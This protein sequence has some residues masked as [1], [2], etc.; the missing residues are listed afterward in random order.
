MRLLPIVVGKTRYRN[1]LPFNP[2]I[3]QNSAAPSD[4][5]VCS[6]NDWIRSFFGSCPRK[7]LVGVQSRSRT[8]GERC[9][10][11]FQDDHNALYFRP[12]FARGLCLERDYEPSIRCRSRSNTPTGSNHCLRHW[13]V[14]RGRPTIRG[15]NGALQL[16]TY[17]TNRTRNSTGPQP[18]RSSF[19]W[20]CSRDPKN[21]DAG[22][23]RGEWTTST[24]G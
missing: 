24:I 20:P 18:R 12:D 22:T 7:R 6:W 14:A 16:P 4:L 9:N 11:I 3:C 10:E 17:T 2:G 1:L 5:Q 13:R 21:G 19:V 15:D 8:E 23:T